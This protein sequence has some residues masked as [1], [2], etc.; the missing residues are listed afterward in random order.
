MARWMQPTAEQEEALAAWI[1]TR[2]EI[3]RNI[4][5]RLDFFELFRLKTTGQRVTLHSVHEDGTVTVCIT[6]QHNLIMFDRK[7]FGIDPDD[8]EPCELP[9]PDELLGTAMTQDEVK[10]NL[11]VLR[12]SVRPDLWQLNSKGK[13][14]KRKKH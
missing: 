1:E 11:D 3:V 4:L 8:L 9:A 14:V 2:P 5:R 10:E 12:V 13:A 7:V 6:G